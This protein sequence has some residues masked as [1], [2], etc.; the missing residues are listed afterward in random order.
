MR[1][2]LFAAVAAS[3]LALTLNPAPA[4][5]SWLSQLLHSYL[6]PGYPGA[7]YPYSP[8][9]PGAYYSYGPAYAAPVYPVVPPVYSN[10][11]PVYSYPWYRSYSVPYVPPYRAYW[12]RGPYVNPWRSWHGW[13]ER[14]ETPWHELR[15][16]YRR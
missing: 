13:H 15:E 12:P 4:K 10:V 11:P 7:Y 6:N 14:H 16:H 1:K 8:G 2:F 5:A 3:A 9:Y